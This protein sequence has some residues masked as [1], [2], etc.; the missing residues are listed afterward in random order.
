MTSLLEMAVQTARQLSPD[1]QDDIARIVL[2]LAGE[3]QP[4]CALSEQEKAS[5]RPSIKQAD[6]R[7]FASESDVE[8]IWAKHG[9]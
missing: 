8:A 9:L 5:L 3:A 2:I 7:E 4:H 6:E 1:A